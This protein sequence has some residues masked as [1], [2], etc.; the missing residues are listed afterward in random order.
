[1]T[2]TFV[3]TDEPLDAHDFF[4]PPGDVEPRPD[5]PLDPVLGDRLREL[6]AQATHV[7]RL[8]I[9]GVRAAVPA[10]LR[11]IAD[12]FAAELAPLEQQA[13][14]I[15]ARDDGSLGA[16]GASWLVEQ[17]AADVRARL[18][19]ALRREANV[20]REELDV[21]DAR[22]RATLAAD[23]DLP[24]LGAAE[25]RT[26]DQLRQQSEGVDAD[27]QLGLLEAVVGKLL[28][29]PIERAGRGLLRA[30]Q[31]RLRTLARDPAFDRAT[32]RGT[33]LALLLFTVDRGARDPAVEGA[34]RARGYLERGRYELDELERAFVDAHGPGDRTLALAALSGRDQ[35]FAVFKVT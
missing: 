33:R 24:V 26:L 2:A 22:Q 35:T 21:L 30:L 32:A 13:A 4:A 16:R 1:M 23:A 19:D 27:E 18:R 34:R 29:A 8:A 17:Q 31:P 12:R 15:A 25:E 3:P 7:A 10:R 6:D 20:A 14:R 9:R 11:A 28:R 5:T